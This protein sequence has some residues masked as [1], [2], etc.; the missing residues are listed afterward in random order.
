M[1]KNQE[2]LFCLVNCQKRESC[3]NAR[4]VIY[5]NYK[6]D[7]ALFDRIE[8]WVCKLKPDV[9]KNNLY[10]KYG[11][12]GIRAIISDF[13]DRVYADPVLV[14]TFQSYRM[15]DV[16][17]YIISLFAY[18]LGSHAHWTGA[19]L[20]VMNQSTHITSDDY[21]KMIR[22]LDD[23]M[24]R[25]NIEIDERAMILGITRSFKYFVIHKKKQ[26]IEQ[27]SEKS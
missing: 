1:A 15:N 23:S 14:H 11:I 10:H 6:E 12:E 9:R 4:V 19:S 7:I 27:K 2:L 25:F 22:Y 13:V 5:W 16:K 24:K 20:K 21:E 18:V 26:I 8:R 3:P 17:R